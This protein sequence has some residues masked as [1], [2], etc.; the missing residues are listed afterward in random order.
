M[1]LEHLELLIYFEK[2]Y[3]EKKTMSNNCFTIVSV[4]ITYDLKNY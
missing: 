3:G 2:S 1:D 4:Y